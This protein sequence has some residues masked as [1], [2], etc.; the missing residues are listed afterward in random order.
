M[1]GKTMG[2]FMDHNNYQSRCGIAKRVT[3][4]ALSAALAM[5][6]LSLVACSPSSGDQNAAS[7]SSSTADAAIPTVTGT[8][9]KDPKYDCAQTSFTAQDLEAAGFQLGDTVNISFGNG[10]TLSDVPYF[11]GYYVK[12]GDPVLVAYPK[13]EFVLVAYNNGQLWSKSKLENGTSISI[14]RNAAGKEATTQEALGQVYST[15]RDDYA[16]DEQ[17]SNFRALAGGSLKQDFLYRGASPV[18]N[19]RNRAATTDGLLKDNGIKTIIDLADSDDDMQGY[20]DADD[21]DSPYA[22]ALYKA[23]DTVTLAMSS[24]YST[25]EYRASVAKGFRFLIKHGGPAYIHC[26]EGK[27]R[28]GFVCML[29][30]SLAG[31]S[32]DEM[33]ADYMKTYDNYYG[34]TADG[35]PERYKAVS[36]LY[37]DEFAEFLLDAKESTDLASGD[38]AAAARKYL[39]EAGMTNKEIDKLT[40]LICK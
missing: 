25:D 38:Y 6:G 12:T 26:T 27:D 36:S 9:S 5:T 7:T 2:K 35:T 15:D 11:N 10:L 39:Q 22:Q 31:A 13:N 8:V 37:F 18:D 34:I 3:A 4:C 28:T 1:F 17:F 23:G 20:F 32:Y 21:F 29:L 33:L 14:T 40:A 24:S 19:S 30:E 16:S